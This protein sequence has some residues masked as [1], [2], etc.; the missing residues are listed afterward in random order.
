M[1]PE[2]DVF[3]SKLV[4]VILRVERTQAGFETISRSTKLS[5]ECKCTDLIYLDNSLSI[6]V[7][8]DAES[9]VILQTKCL[10]YSPRDYF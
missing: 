8:T 5:N 9:I 3:V 4:E 10:L 2:V 7:I 1:V 6:L